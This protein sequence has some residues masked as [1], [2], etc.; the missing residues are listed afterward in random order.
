VRCGEQRFILDAGAGLRGLGDELC[1]RGE[2]IGR[3]RLA[4]LLKRDA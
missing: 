1:M 3:N 2:H 4:R